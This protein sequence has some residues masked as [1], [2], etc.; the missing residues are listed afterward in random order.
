M[1]GP[2]PSSALPLRRTL[3]RSFLLIFCFAIPGL[4]DG[5]ALAGEACEHDPCYQGDALQNMCSPCVTAICEADPSCCSDTWDLACALA[6]DDLC[7]RCEPLCGDATEDRRLTAPDALQALRTAVS[8]GDCPTY[9]C[10]FN[11]DGEVLA[12]DALLILRVAVGT[13]ANANCP[14][15]PVLHQYVVSELFLPQDQDQAEDFAFNI[16][17]DVHDG[18]DNQLGFVLLALAMQG[19]NLQ[20]TVDLAIQSGELVELASLLATDLTTD[21]DATWQFHAGEPE[22]SPPVFDGTDV[23]EVA[24]S[25]VV[26]DA[27]IAGGHL[28]GEQAVGSQETTPLRFT[29]VPGVPAFEFSIIGLHVD[30]FVTDDGCTQGRI[31]GAISEQEV[32]EEF[33]PSWATTIEEGI[34]EE[35]RA[36]WIKDDTTA[37]DPT[38]ETYLNLFDE[39]PHDGHISIDEVRENGF[40]QTLFSPDVSVLDESDAYVPNPDDHPDALSFAF[41]F[42]CAPATF[43]E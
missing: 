19:F 11:G 20:E 35:C 5:T 8:I 13:S 7:A 31:G 15:G 29:L 39:E 36:G 18:K 12:V 9:L 17:D 24:Q 38:S 28:S 6:T 22:E 26:V 14:A 3:L 33:L 4:G 37:C 21:A 30:V 42:H 23:F 32:F 16:D 41:G 10:D 25:G 27:T 2:E 40:V 1:P 43:A 34:S